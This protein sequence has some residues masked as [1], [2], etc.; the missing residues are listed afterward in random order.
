M[1]NRSKKFKCRI[2]NNDYLKVR[3]DSYENINGIEF[4]TVVE[5]R[6]YPVIFLNKQRAKDLRDHLNKMLEEI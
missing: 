6:S 3:L 2:N 4:E 5:E 1:R